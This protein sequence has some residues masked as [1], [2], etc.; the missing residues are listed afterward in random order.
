[1]YTIFRA[2]SDLSSITEKADNIA[3]IF[4]ACA[5]YAEDPDLITLKVWDTKDG[6]F[7]VDYYKDA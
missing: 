6:T 2:Y 5:I 1:M 4:G 7:I 3:N